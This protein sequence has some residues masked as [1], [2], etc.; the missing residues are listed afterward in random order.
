[1]FGILIPT[2]ASHVRWTMCANAL[3]GGRSY[4]G[5]R[6][7]KSNHAGATLRSLTPTSPLSLYRY[8]QKA[9]Q[10][11]ALSPLTPSLLKLRLLGAQCGTHENE[12]ADAVQAGCT[13]GPIRG[14]VTWRRQR[15][16]MRKT[17]T[18]QRKWAMPLE[19]PLGAGTGVNYYRV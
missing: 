10:G 8:A 16:A 11:G 14:A 19:G 17:R 5:W 12:Y 3:S 1:M 15:G 9:G 2:S 4:I 18:G 13:A 6:P 7:M